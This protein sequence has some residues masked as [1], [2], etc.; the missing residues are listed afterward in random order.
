MEQ[1]EELKTAKTLGIVSLIGA[2]VF[3]PVGIV[4]GHISLGKYKKLSGATEGKGFA[5]AG[6]I[7][8][9]I[10]LI[11]TIVYFIAAAVFMKK[12]AENPGEYN[13]VIEEFQDSLE[14]YQENQ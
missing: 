6:L 10:A 5:K 13:Q 12:L 1:N 11:L 9:Y 2:F 7:I 14:E 8:G 4:C 3:W